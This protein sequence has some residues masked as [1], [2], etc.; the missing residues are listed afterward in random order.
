MILFLK[1]LAKGKKSRNFMRQTFS[2]KTKLF[3][4][5]YQNLKKRKKNIKNRPLMGCLPHG[6]SISEDTGRKADSE[7]SG[8][9]CCDGC[10]P[11][12]SRKLSVS[13]WGQRI[14]L[15]FREQRCEGVLQLFLQTD[16]MKSTSADGVSVTDGATSCWQGCC[17]CLQRTD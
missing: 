8:G 5:I 11:N 10:F 2:F 4:C 13:Y 17:V 12:Y 7:H 15:L 16:I 1:A 3:E 14:R 6:V 9:L